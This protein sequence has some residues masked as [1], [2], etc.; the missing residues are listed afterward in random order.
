MLP[1]FLKI[2]EIKDSV[3]KCAKSTLSRIPQASLEQRPVE[4]RTSSEHQ[5]LWEV[6]QHSI[7]KFLRKKRLRK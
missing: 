6:T 2:F 1:V 7:E 4:Q 5:T 3:S